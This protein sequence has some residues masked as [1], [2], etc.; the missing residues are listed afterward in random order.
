[1]PAP[2]VGIDLGTTHSL[3]AVMKGDRPELIPNRYG[4]RLTPSVVGLDKNGQVHVGESAKNQ[5]VTAPERT[6]LEVKRLM[7]SGQKVTLGDRT[8]T[9]QE[10]SGFIL[11][12]LK[13]DATTMR[14][15]AT[16]A[17]TT[18]SITLN[19]WIAGGIIR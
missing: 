16:L 7:G 1:M 19:A 10:I 3:V 8:Y 2:V 5:L 4:K 11:K 9:P 6:V 12:A 18:P 14:I 15:A 17:G 13:D